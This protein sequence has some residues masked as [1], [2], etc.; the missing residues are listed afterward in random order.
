MY[1]GYPSF[2]RARK[3]SEKYIEFP[4][5]TWQK[6]FKDIFNTLKE[7]DSEQVVEEKKK[8]EFTTT[9]INEGSQLRISI[10]ASTLVKVRIYN[11]NL[12]LYYSNF[13]FS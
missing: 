5:P 12:E 10:P 8:V 2:T 7:Y 9:V 13:P 11:I 1:K 3:L 6:I 4:I